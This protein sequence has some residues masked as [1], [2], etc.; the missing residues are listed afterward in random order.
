MRSAD[1]CG[2]LAEHEE[3][4]EHPER[5]LQQDHVG[6]EGDER[7]DGDLAVDGE[8]CRRRA[9]RAASPRRGRFSMTGAMRART[10]TCCTAAHRSRR[11]ARASSAIWRRSAAKPFTT[12]TPLMFSSTIVATSAMRAW[13]I[14]RQREDAVAQRDARAGTRRAARPPRRA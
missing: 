1:A 12:R 2:P 10:S 8:L 6:V 9:A 13:T 14:Q 4:A 7:A 3:E 11:A 5:R